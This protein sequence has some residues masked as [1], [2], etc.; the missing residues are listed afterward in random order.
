VVWRRVGGGGGLKIETWGKRESERCGSG[1]ASCSSDAGREAFLTSLVVGDAAGRVRERQLCAKE[2]R[3][4]ERES[5][6]ELHNTYKKKAMPPPICSIPWSL[7]Q[8]DTKIIFYYF[9]KI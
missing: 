9:Q 7:G 5:F 4:R 2:G 1:L 8:L 3:E 6:Q